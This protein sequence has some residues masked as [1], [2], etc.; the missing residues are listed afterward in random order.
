MTIRRILRY[1]DPGLFRV[2]SAVTS[3]DSALSEL[4]DDLLE[5]MRAAPGVGITA[6]HIG[7]DQ[8]IFVLELSKQDGVRVYVNPVILE[9][10][11]GTIIFNEGSV[12]MPGVIEEVERPK[13]VR[14]RYQDLTGAMHEEEAHGF[15]AVC[16][17]HEIDQLD[18]I[19][20]LQ[21]LSR[22]KRERLVTKWKKSQRG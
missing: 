13:S 7:V 8:R 11:A 9:C 17:Q 4:A 12:S 1:P 5:T 21:R 16:I 19:F 20:W 6:A 18:G 22:L 14:L 3:F 2:C 15:H 10:D